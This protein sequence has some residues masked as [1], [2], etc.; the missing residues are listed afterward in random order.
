[1][2]P[3]IGDANSVYDRIA[4]SRHLSENKEMHQEMHVRN[5]MTAVIGVRK[6]GDDQL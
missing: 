1:M 6:V 2:H 3:K 4:A 5:G